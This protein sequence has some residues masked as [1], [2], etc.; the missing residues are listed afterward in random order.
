MGYPT[1][2]SLSY[3]IFAIFTAICTLARP[4]EGIFIG[5]IGALLACPGCALLDRLQIDDP[6]GCV[7]TH[8]IAAIWGL[9]SVAFFAE[10]D[11]LTESEFGILKGGPVRFLGVQL[12]TAVAVS[13]WA[14]LTTFLELLLVDKLVG[15]R[16]SPEEEMLGADQ[17]EHGIGS[18]GPAVQPRP[19]AW[20]KDNGGQTNGNGLENMAYEAEEDAERPNTTPSVSTLQGHR[21]IMVNTNAELISEP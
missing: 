12:L 19:H 13:G 20:Q 10:K 17:V 11:I 14:A 21:V 1:E 9:L 7:P 3:L 2:L 18:N 6:V 8:G 4:W 5:A 16:M 15:M